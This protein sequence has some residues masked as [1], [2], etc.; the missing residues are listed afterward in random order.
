MLDEPLPLVVEEDEGE[1]EVER[2]VVGEKD[3]NGERDEEAVVLGV[4]E[5]VA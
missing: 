4:G 1:A 5:R 2:E 3:G